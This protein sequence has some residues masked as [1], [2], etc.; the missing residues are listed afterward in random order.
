MSWPDRVRCSSHVVSHLWYLLISFVRHTA[1]SKFFN[2][3]V[4]SVSTDRGTCASLL[5]SLCPLSSLL[6]RSQ[7]SAK[8]SHLAWISIIE[9]QS[10]GSCRHPTVHTS[11]PILSCSANSL[12]CLLFG[13]YFSIYD[14][15][16]RPW[17]VLPCPHLLDGV[18]YQ[19][20]QVLISNYSTSAFNLHPA[21]LFLDFPWDTSACLPSTTSLFCT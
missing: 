19:Q 7:H 10:W 16:S 11:H 5:C 3:L 14:L 17:G 18:F 2:T 6:Q 15:G 4:P 8:L 20:Q 21:S 13:H 1:S 12:C 9:N